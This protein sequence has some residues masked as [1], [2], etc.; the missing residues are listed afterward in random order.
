MY[1][2]QELFEAGRGCGL[3]PGSLLQDESE[4]RLLILFVDGVSADG[5]ACVKSWSRKRGLRLAMVE[6]EEK[7]Q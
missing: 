5:E 6:I 1:S 7:S 2:D 3:A 4:P